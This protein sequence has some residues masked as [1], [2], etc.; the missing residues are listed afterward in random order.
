VVTDGGSIAFCRRQGTAPLSL[1]LTAADGENP[2]QIAEVGLRTARWLPDGS[3][4]VYLGR[5][6]QHHVYDA[7]S[8]G[9]ITGDIWRLS[10]AK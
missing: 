10:R 2:Q 4:V 5:D 3:G 1:W 9:K 8:R 6:R 7:Y